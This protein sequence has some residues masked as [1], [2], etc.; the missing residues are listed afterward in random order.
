MYIWVVVLTNKKGIFFEYFYYYYVII[1]FI[2]LDL[3]VTKHNSVITICSAL[4]MVTTKQ[5]GS[6]VFNDQDNN[7][8]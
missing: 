1:T 8:K 5:R 4:N 3:I 7:C 2:I 6:A